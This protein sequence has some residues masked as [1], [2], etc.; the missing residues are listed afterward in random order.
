LNVL[1]NVQLAAMV[2]KGRL[3]YDKAVVKAK[4]EALLGTLGLSHRLEHR[5]GELS[6]GE[7]QRVALARA[8]I[9][10]PPLLLADEP[11][12]NLDAKTGG[13][14][15][16]QLLAHRA[17]TKQTMVIVTHSAEVAARA[18]RVVRLVEGRVVA[19]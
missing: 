3:R 1:E 19:E 11:T 8:L 4:A 10:D 13:A 12:G 6:G 17:A 15:M 7:R 2:S 14:I 18:D 9:N 16:D 5:S